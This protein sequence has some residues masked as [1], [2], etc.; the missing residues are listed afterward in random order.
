MVVQSGLAR[1]QLRLAVPAQLRCACT[2]KDELARLPGVGEALVFGAGDYAMRI[3]L[4]PDKVA[5]RGL[6]AGDVVRAVREQNMQVSAGQLG[7]EPMPTDSDF[8]IS[9]NARG[10]LQT[11]QEFG[12]I[13]LKTGE[14]RRGGAPADVARIELGA[15]DYTL[16]AQLDNKECGGDRHLPGARRQRAGDRDAVRAKMDELATRFP[17]GIE[18]R[19][20]ST[21]RRSSCATRSR[22]WSPRCWRRWCWSCWW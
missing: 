19:R 16:R 13:V 2:I 11:E 8:L 5:S 17:P 12:D 9:I 4:D 15:G 14:R 10:R 22:P 20:R 18:L 6:T 7:A 1:R 3:W 21:T